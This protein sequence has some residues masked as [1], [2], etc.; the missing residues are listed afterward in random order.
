ML[1]TT[2]HDDWRYFILVFRR[3]NMKGG[4]HVKR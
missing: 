1:D 2:D 4:R 3:G